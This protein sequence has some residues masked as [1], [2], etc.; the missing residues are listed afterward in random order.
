MSWARLRAFMDTHID[1]PV[2]IAGATVLGSIVFIINYDYG[3]SSALL[4]AGKQATYMF[5]A[6]GYMVRLNQRLA[7]SSRPAIV[8]CVLSMLGTGA[9]ETKVET[10]AQ[11]V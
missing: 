8:R 11:R 9:V 10:H 4:A 7:L 6:G 3:C 2:A 5:F 1:Y